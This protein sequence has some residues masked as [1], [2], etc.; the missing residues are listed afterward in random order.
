M[1]RAKSLT[2]DLFMSLRQNRLEEQMNPDAGLDQVVREQKQKKER[3]YRRARRHQNVIDA[4]YDCIEDLARASKKA[5]DSIT[6]LTH[7]RY[8]GTANIQICEV[9]QELRCGRPQP[10][11]FRDILDEALDAEKSTLLSQREVLLN[12]E[13]EGKELI[14]QMAEKRA[15]LTRNSGER[16]VNMLHDIS[17]LN[18][19]VAMPPKRPPDGSPTKSN[20]GDQDS[21][22]REYKQIS[23]LKEE[24]KQVLAETSEL[25]ERAWNHRKQTLETV[26][27]FSTRRELAKAR[28]E[29]SLT[30]R[31]EQLSEE[32]GARDTAA[33]LEILLLEG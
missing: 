22:P 13:E 25:L 6:Q 28:A 18:Q 23:E 20:R 9:R 30:K 26:R 17:S 27:Q 31:V 19:K 8:K 1:N 7:E 2:R 14:N 11:L 10:E 24:S 16:R 5:V 21:G 12:M 32:V 29:A 33:G 3:V 4:S 15:L